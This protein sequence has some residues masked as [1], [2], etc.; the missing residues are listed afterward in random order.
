MRARVKITP[1]K[2][3]RLR[4]AFLA[5]GDFHARSRFV[6]STVPEENWGTTRSLHP[7]SLLS[8]LMR[9]LLS[10]VQ[11]WATLMMNV[12]SLKTW[13]FHLKQSISPTFFFLCLI[14]LGVV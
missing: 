10:K 5:W 9:T 14:F 6:R 8:N 12:Q 4:L 1:H 13:H 2:E 3:R 7:T 11:D